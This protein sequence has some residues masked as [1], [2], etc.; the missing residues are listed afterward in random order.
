[1]VH[2]VCQKLKIN[3]QINKYNWNL[4]KK[5][6]RMKP[7]VNHSEKLGVQTSIQED[8]SYIG[9][10]ASVSESKKYKYDE[11]FLTLLCLISAPLSTFLHF[12]LGLK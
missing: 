9:Y 12:W 10:I 2:A 11:Y 5:K 4:A 7:S 1:M 6:P 8:F 3:E